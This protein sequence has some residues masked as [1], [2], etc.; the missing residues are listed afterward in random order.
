[1]GQG[2]ISGSAKH[3]NLK[4]AQTACNSKRRIIFVIKIVKYSGYDFNIAASGASDNGMTFAMGF[5]M[6]AGV[7]AT[8]TTTAKKVDAQ[9]RCN[10][11][12]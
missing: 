6:G 10:R 11:W 8:K 12:C 2:R 4:S 9:Q 5:D 3:E 7:I 1:M